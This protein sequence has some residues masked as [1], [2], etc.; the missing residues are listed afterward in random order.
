MQE[1][2]HLR[3]HER[4]TRI[5]RIRSL[6]FLVGSTIDRALDRSI[7]VYESMTLRGFGRGMLV[8]GSGIKK[9]DI[10][11]FIGLAV[12]ILVFLYWLPLAVLLS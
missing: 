9:N 2:Q 1:A 6:G 12:L 4:G 8:V 3:G 10:V 11:L 7:I 5:D